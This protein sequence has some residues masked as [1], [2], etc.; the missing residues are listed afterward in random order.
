MDIDEIPYYQE[1]QVA[2]D[3]FFN[4]LKRVLTSGIMFVLAFIVSNMTLQLLVAWIS[5]LLK[6]TIRFSYNQVKVFPWDYHYWSRTNVVLIFFLSPFICLVLGLILL[7]VLRVYTTWANAFRIFLFWLAVNLVNQVLT[8]A[9]LSPLGSPV[10]RHNGLYQTFSVVGTFL[11]IN[12]TLMAIMA[13]GALISIMLL[14]IIV[15][16]ELMRYSF[17]KTLILN[18]KG[19]DTVVIQVF[20]I[21]VLIGALPVMLLCSTA[22]IFTTVMQLAN[23]GVVCIGIFLMNS[24]GSANVRCNKTDVLNHLPVIEMLVCATIW[25]AVF[26]YFK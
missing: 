19:M 18:K 6:Y 21:P 13:V 4:K 10:D 5:R 24:I 8:H 15:R 22:G 11:W 20:V 12:P 3:G 26:T 2:G 16:D 7:I 25:F 14:G 1:A 9:L 17:S 23:L